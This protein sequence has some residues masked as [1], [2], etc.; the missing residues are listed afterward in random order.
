MT[1]QNTTKTKVG[2]VLRDMMQSTGVWCFD[3][4]T[5][6][7]FAE[8]AAK[9]GFSHLEIGGGQSFQIALLSHSN[10]YRIM[11]EIKK[12]LDQQERAVAPQILLRGANQFGF[13]HFSKATQQKNLDLL[14]EAAGDSD[15]SRALVIRIFDA[16]NDIENL[17]FCIEYL[18]AHN[19]KAQAEGGK[20]VSVQIA[21]SYVAPKRSA[22]GETS[23][24]YSIDYY[25]AYAKALRSIA[26]EAGGDL[27]SFCIKDMSGQLVAS[28][29][30]KLTKALKEVGL[31]VILHCHSTDEAKSL[32][33][34]IASAQAGIDAIEVAVHPLAGGASH[35]NVRS[36]AQFDHFT[37]LNQDELADLEVDLNAIFAE[38]AVERK[39]F[40]VPLGGLKRLAALG[41]PGGAIPFILH[42]LQEQVCTMLRIDM[43][44]ALD[45]FANELDRVQGLLGQVPLVTP[46]ADIVA[47]QVIKN[48]GN[49]AR[50][51]NYK[52]MDPRF[53]SLVLGR[54]GEV[55]DYVTQTKVAID[56]QLVEE[57]L[58]YCRGIEP[59]ADGTRIKAGK[60]FPEPE[61]TE[62]HPS[63]FDDNQEL[64]NA[65]YYV[66]E[67][68]QRYPDSVQRFGS[69]DECVMTQVMRPAGNNERLLTRNIL[70]P[71]E[72]RL[73]L[74]L[75]ETL[76][77]LPWQRIPEARDQQDNEVT[78]LALL[79]LLG[80]YE[81]IVSNIKSFITH[82]RKDNLHDSLESLKDK[83]VSS[84]CDSNEEAAANRLY[85]EKRFVALFAAAVFWDLQ[86]IC[87][88][89]GSDSREGLDEMTAS[90][91][92][93]IISVTL[94]QRK[95]EGRGQA[96]S[97]LA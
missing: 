66:A 16:L 39:D 83:I 93:R 61:L 6:S 45:A 88:R 3:Q 84:Y 63:Q 58:D 12:E 13:K 86:R 23:T 29:A 50:A 62:T 43:D 40:A 10:P 25:V 90:S 14:I 24:L 47:K 27:D 69:L 52:L 34:V 28:A 77:L 60:P 36:I 8:R 49:E 11:R 89:T 17:R 42:D 1:D 22:S 21:L 76:H 55:I 2:W 71:T 79:D 15:K 80:D 82:T 68:S 92:G 64:Q 91:L 46:T 59:D 75:D 44:A 73:R 72:H 95:E 38:R 54:Y 18:V 5:L 94:R 48:L 7:N 65:E 87:R 81:G 78:D 37:P 35:H 74:L 20:Q 31:P 96:K 57:V 30:I 41:I 9:V 4:A 32:S 19:K 26:L 85:I 67:L 56:P 53:C 70:E 33:A 51:E 97:Y